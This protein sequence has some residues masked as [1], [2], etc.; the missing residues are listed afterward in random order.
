M[1]MMV[2][3]IRN[4]M[5]M[6]RLSHLISKNFKSEKQLAWQLLGLIILA[7]YSY[8]R[9][10]MGSYP[11]RIKLKVIFRGASWALSERKQA[12][13][14]TTL[15][16]SCKSFP[17]L[18]LDFLRQNGNRSLLKVPCRVDSHRYTKLRLVL[19]GLKFQRRAC[20]YSHRLFSWSQLMRWLRL[21]TFLRR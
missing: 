16:L 13:N 5:L 17:L 2:P 20:Y 9:C 10:L 11:D 12:L 15:H 4:L 7:T 1:I 6:L 18:G 19:Q 21:E 8:Y 14:I 3:E